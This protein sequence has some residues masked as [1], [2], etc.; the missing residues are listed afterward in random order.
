MC[1]PDYPDG[2]TGISLIGLNLYAELRS[3]CSRFAF[4]YLNMNFSLLMSGS[5]TKCNT[6]NIDAWRQFSISLGSL[7]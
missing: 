2:H 3:I 7:S 4:P 6:K 1:V 5:G